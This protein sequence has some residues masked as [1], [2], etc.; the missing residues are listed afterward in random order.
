MFSHRA[1]AFKYFTIFGDT[2][3]ALAAFG[4]AYG[5]R[6]NLASLRELYSLEFY[7]WLLPLVVG[8]W[9]GSGVV[10]RIYRDAEQATPD[11]ALLDPI[12]LNLLAMLLLFAV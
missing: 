5:V 4:L 1:Q 7:P 6:G 12:K 2:L 9:L 10:L 3:A 11:R 8:L